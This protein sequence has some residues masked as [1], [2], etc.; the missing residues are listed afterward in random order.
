M[1]PL[2]TPPPPPQDEK[3]R[4]RELEEA[5]RREAARKGK[6]DSS[7]VAIV[8]RLQRKRFQQVFNFLDKAGCG[9]VSLAA[10]LEEPPEYLDELDDD[11][12]FARGGGC[13]SLPCLL[14]GGRSVSW[15]GRT[16]C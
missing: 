3:A 11:V 9:F 15:V 16:G 6:V 10:I 12:S 2:S 4:Q 1:H 14:T 5:R 7:S 13:D 8:R